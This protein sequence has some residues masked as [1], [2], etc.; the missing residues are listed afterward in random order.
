M[1]LH[2][3]RALITQTVNKE[4]YINVTALMVMVEHSVMVLLQAQHVLMHVIEE[5]AVNH[6]MVFIIVFTN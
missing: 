1:E 3:F 6:K 4:H 5:A 2:V